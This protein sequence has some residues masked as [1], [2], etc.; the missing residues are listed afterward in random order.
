MERPT[1]VPFWRDVRVLAVLSQIAFVLVL[2]AF[3]GFLFANLSTAMRQRGLVAGFDY[4]RN[5]SG[6]EIGE[7]LIP[8]RPT[9]TYGRAYIVGLL[10]TLSVS[11]IG[12]ILSTI[13]GVIVGVAR[14]STNWLINRLAAIYIEIIRNTPLLVQLVFIYFGVFFQ[15]PP[16][17]QTLELPGGV[18]ANQRGLFVPRPIVSPTFLPWLALM[19]AGIVAAVVIWKLVTR[20]FKSSTLG[21]WL[22]TIVVLILVPTLGWVLLGAPPLTFEVPIRERFNFRGGLTLTPE[23]SAL[24][25]GLVIYTAGFIAE[26][27]R[28]GIQAVGRG[29][30]EAANAIGLSPM[31]ILRLVIF[32]QAMRVIVPPLTSQYLNL[33]KN[34]SL[35]IAIGFPD[36]FAVNQTIANQTGQ[37]VPAIALMMGTYLLMSLFTSLIMN[38]YNRSVQILER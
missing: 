33:A 22:A 27:V 2:A 5:E 14:L 3:A 19:A 31:Q 17:N 13:L 23:F 21:T 38:I 18:F 11:V 9:D 28:G 12:I 6:F 1:A 35:A 37:P 30:I 36:M 10:N 16:V 8:Y 24:L 4:L 20:V 25:T 29:Q 15:L 32:P 34:S 26:V 7:G